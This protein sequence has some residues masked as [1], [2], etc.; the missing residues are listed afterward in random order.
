MN[1]F[2]VILLSSRENY[3]NELC[4]FI[5]Q[6]LSKIPM[7]HTHTSEKERGERDRQTDRNRQTNRERE[8][9]R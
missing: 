6:R 7:V 5:P 4:G 9:D 1:F 3:I 2:F 8:R